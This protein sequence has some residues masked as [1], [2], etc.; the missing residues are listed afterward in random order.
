MI[1]AGDNSWY[2]KIFR[3]KETK[4][5]RVS[6][7]GELLVTESF[8]EKNKKK[9]GPFFFFLFFLF[10]WTERTAVTWGWGGNL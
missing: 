7:W 6:V 3:A 1:I 5:A 9:Q 8:L 10:L 2:E 4:A